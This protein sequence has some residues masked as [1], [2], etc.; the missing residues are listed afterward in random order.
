[1]AGNVVCEQLCLTF[2]PP[3]VTPR[4]DGSYVVSPGKPV[5]WLSVRQM[6]VMLGVGKTQSYQYVEEGLVESR[7]PAPHKIQVAAESVQRLAERIRDPEFWARPEFLPR[8]N[9]ENAETSKG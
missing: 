1:M 4:G 6:Q 9:A 5:Q 8:E 2:G 7:R 3:V